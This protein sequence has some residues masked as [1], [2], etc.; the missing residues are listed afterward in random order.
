MIN[1][2]NNLL[3]SVLNNIDTAV[4]IHKVIENDN[5]DFQIIYV[6]HEF[7]ILTG[8]TSQSLVGKNSSQ[9]NLPKYMK[10]DW[11]NSYNK[12]DYSKFSL[13]EVIYLKETDKSYNVNVYSPDKDLIAVH[14]KEIPLQKN[15]INDKA[16]LAVQLFKS[17][18]IPIFIWKYDNKDDFVLYYSNDVAVKFTNNI[19]LLGQKAS[20]FFSDIE[21][22]Q[23]ITVCCR[24]KMNIDKIIHYKMKTTDTTKLLQLKLVFIE[25]DMVAIHTID[26]TEFEQYK[27]DFMNTRA[28]LES[29]FEQNPNPMIIVD[30]PD[31]ILRMI[32][33]S[34]LT[35]LEIEDEPSYIG[36][37]LL[38]IKQSWRDFKPDGDQL[39]AETMPLALALKGITTKN[40]E[41]HMI[42]KNGNEKWELMSASPIYNKNHELIGG[43]AVFPD[44]SEQKK[45]EELMIMAMQE[46]DIARQQAVDANTAKSEFLANMSHEIRTPMNAILGFAEI[47]RNKINN[48]LFVSY[49]DGIITA[50]KNLLNLI[51]DILDLSKVESGRLVIESE[52]VDLRAVCSDIKQIFAL[53]AQEKNITLITDIK[54]TVPQ[55]IILDETRLRQILFNLVGNALKFTNEG[56]VS[57]SIYGQNIETRYMLIIDITDTGIGIPDSQKERIF[58]AFTQQSGQSYRKYGGTGL[59]LTISKRL[60]EILGASISLESTVGKG[61]RFSIVFKS[62]DIT[63]SGT[64]DVINKTDEYFMNN[65]SFPDV[66]ILIAEDDLTNRIV[67]KGFL[68]N[69]NAVIF[70]AENGSE[71]IEM[72]LMHKPDIILMDMRMPVMTGYDAVKKIRNDILMKDIPIIAITASLMEK[73]EKDIKNLCN[74]YIRKPVNQKLLFSEMIKYVPYSS[75]IVKTENH[76]EFKFLRFSNELSNIVENEILPLWTEI[77]KMIS[78]DDVEVF[79]DKLIHL[80][81]KFENDSLSNYANNLRNMTISFNIDNMTSLFLSFPTLFKNRLA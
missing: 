29:T 47:L 78:N 74:A 7:E 50:G 60:A 25:P 81:K 36:Q 77:N 68:E 14:L 24:E 75:G 69:S 17:I 8:L 1:N 61:S 11:I 26:I 65:I 30:Y 31:C 44:I 33:S 43:L 6:N 45:M 79:A 38:T 23:A 49:L 66:K 34:C 9:L 42:T 46:A 2:V 18:P 20:V 27:T 19:N 52:S 67:L 35:Y 39:S 76:P 5:N 12:T 10:D 80:S 40:R 72:T 71:A 37:S 63:V 16:N 21:I 70:E 54:A 56:N 55:H 58:E 48:D 15:D 32:N 59:G 64:D 13:S 4:V 51:N 22:F 62:V 28:L 3:K 41:L 57:I 73:D 53:K